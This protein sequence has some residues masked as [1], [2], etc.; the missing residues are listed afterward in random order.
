M[1]FEQKNTF[2]FLFTLRCILGNDI[3]QSILTMFNTTIAFCSA[4]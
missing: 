3:K 4:F 2:Q 1:E